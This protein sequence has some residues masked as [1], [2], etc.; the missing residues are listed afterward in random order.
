MKWDPWS[1]RNMFTIIKDISYMSSNILVLLFLKTDIIGSSHVVTISCTHNNSPLKFDHLMGKLYGAPTKIFESYTYKGF[2][3]MYIWLTTP[4]FYFRWL[5]T[6]SCMCFIDAFPSIV[7]YWS[8][9]SYYGIMS[10]LAVEL[11]CY[12]FLFMVCT[13][14]ISL[15][16]LPIL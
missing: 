7:G 15:E 2:F 13:W 6:W 4:I 3:T 12:W 16:F 5:K 1:K 14:M 11:T 10:Y 9:M 8:N